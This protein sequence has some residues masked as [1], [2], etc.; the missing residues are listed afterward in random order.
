[1]TDAAVAIRERK[2]LAWEDVKALVV[3]SVSSPHSK[4]AYA[5][6]LEEFAQWAR[7]EEEAGRGSAAFSKAVAQR[8]RSFLEQKGLSPSSI[9]VALT[10][11][12]KL[13]TEAA[14]NGLLD[15][16]AAIGRIR[17]APRK[18][19]RV[20]RWLTHE[21]AR[22]LLRDNGA[23]SLKAKRD[24]ALLC[25]LLGAGLRRAEIVSLEVGHI[26]QREGRWVV[27]D[28]VG[29]R[30]RI[31]TVPIPAWAKAALDRWTAT[32]PSRPPRNTSACG[33][34]SGM[35]PAII[36]ELKLTDGAYHNF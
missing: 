21:Q 8:Y 6:P 20:G 4:R 23:Q 15:A 13:A 11:V 10:A 19:Q 3:D 29:K 28:L 27:A 16:A 30:K 14:D 7:E 9:N 31:R 25:L 35:R 12:K 36:W 18:G 1:M 34:T 5:R 24:R 17:G 22:L 33:R 32:T 26:Q 2:P